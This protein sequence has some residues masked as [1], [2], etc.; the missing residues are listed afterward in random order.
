MEVS[1]KAL[2][3]HGLGSCRSMGKSIKY[4]G[5]RD[6]GSYMSFTVCKPSTSE[7]SLVYKIIG[8]SGYITF[9]KDVFDS[10]HLES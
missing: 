6:K 3:C 8:H 2:I 1:H 7:Y 10:W 5:I 4:K 9:Y